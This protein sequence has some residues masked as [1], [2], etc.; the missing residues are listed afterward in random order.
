[1]KGRK[2]PST[3]QH[4]RT[5]HTKS[6]S[7]NPSIMSK[8][9]MLLSFGTLIQ[10]SF[11]P[12]TEAILPT[13]AIDVR[14]N[15]GTCGETLFASQASFGTWPEMSEENNSPMIPTM[16]PDD[17]PLLCLGTTQPSSFTPASPFVLV[18]PRGLC[19]FEQKTLVAQ[20]LGASG[21]II[22]GN[23][24]SRYSLNTTQIEANN[25]QVTTNDIIYPAESHDYDCDKASA[26]IPLSQ[27]SFDQLPYDSAR[28]DPILTGSAS[29]GN[30]CAA[31]NENFSESCTSQRCLLTGNIENNDKT[32]KACCA[33]DF[34]VWLYND[35][36]ITADVKIPAL[37]ITM[38][39][40]DALFQY[41]QTKQ[42]TVTMYTRYYPAY[43]LSS[44]VIWALGVFIAGLAAWMSASDY[45]NAKVIN[46]ASPSDMQPMDE[47]S[48]SSASGNN[49]VHQYEQL[50]GGKMVREESLELSA[51][52]ACG[53]IIFS[54]A[55]LLILFIFKIY[56]VVKIFYAFGC[57]G[58][59]FQ[60]IFYPLFHRLTTKMGL[61]DRIAFTTETL[62]LG[63]VSY[64][65]LLAA[66]A[67]YGLGAVWTYISFT[68]RHP[69]AILFFWVMQ[70]I[71]GACMC[72][73]FLA[74]MKLNSIK[75]ASILLTAAFFYDI[76]FVFVTPLLTK[77]GK[78]I[79]VDVAT[80]GGK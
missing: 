33:W 17:D 71:M 48:N 29:Q 50:E 25:N 52:H 22:Y 7:S 67:S 21:I 54:S 31:Q 34:H 45:R 13:G 65:Q 73:L 27:L 53:F 37:Y 36:N 61:R 46:Q 57:S 3:Q 26:D 58:A 38:V 76:F 20:N 80:S 8:L 30:L 19:S 40:T 60:V 39:E 10:L 66:I 69:D 16:P 6:Q 23:V 12:L 32:M 35:G 59:M 77:G 47:R 43:N 14:C 2:E 72:I 70:D 11:L 1:M 51:S 15:D 75:V 64:V 42:I 28:N 24:A 68:Q 18:A 78:S 74:T 79:M 44:V 41:M 55:G 4:H 62:E 56:N 63:D 9:S 49:N 5:I